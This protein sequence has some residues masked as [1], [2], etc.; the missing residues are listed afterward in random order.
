M[1]KILFV[2]EEHWQRLGIMYLSGTLKKQ[3]HQ[4]DLAISADYK[5]VK[6]ALIKFKPDAVG[7]SIMTGDHH[8]AA[9]MASKIK[10]DLFLIIFLIVGLMML[11][12]FC[13]HSARGTITSI[14]N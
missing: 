7:F 4:V 11:L 5:D 9:D 13:N 14:N 12:Y 3:G 2:Q 6:S 10:I 8:W 1:A